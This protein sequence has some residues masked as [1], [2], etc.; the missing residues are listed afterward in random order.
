MGLTD[1]ATGTDSHYNEVT[2][3]Q[4]EALNTPTSRGA[5]FMTMSCS[6]DAQET[7]LV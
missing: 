4:N 2:N 1:G 6:S 3:A 7:V 5:Q